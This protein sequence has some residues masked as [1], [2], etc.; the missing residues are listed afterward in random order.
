MNDGMTL[1]T[2]PQ[3]G[4][5]Y[6]P[7]VDG[8]RAFA[9]IAVILYHLN[10]RLLP[11]GFVGVDVFFV[12]SGFVVTAS[13]AHLN[14]KSFP[15]F[16]AFFYMRRIRRIYP[17]LVCCLLVTTMCYVLFIPRAWLSNTIENTGVAAF[18]GL[19]NVV[20][21]S[22]TDTYFS[23]RSEYNPFTHTWSLGVEEQFYLLFPILMYA[24]Q[25]FGYSQVWRLRLICGV[26]ILCVLSLWLS[27]VLTNSDWQQAFYGLPGR[28]WELGC[29]MILCL[30]AEKWVPAL[31]RCKPVRIILPIIAL[32]ATAISLLLPEGNYFPFPLA[33]IPVFGT[34]GIIASVVSL[35]RDLIGRLFGLGPVVFIGKISYS[36]YLWHWPVFVLMKWTVGLQGLLWSIVAIGLTG[37]LALASYYWVEN[38]IRRLPALRAMS[39]GRIIAA[40]FASL[41]VLATVGYE[42]FEHKDRLS[43]TQTRD[44]VLWYPDGIRVTTG[45]RGCKLSFQNHDLSGVGVR[46]FKPTSCPT[47]TA[48]GRLIVVGDSHAGAYSVLLQRYALESGREVRLYFA[49][50]CSFLTLVFPASAACSKFEGVITRDLAATVTSSDIVFLPSLRLQRFNDEW[51]EPDPVTPQPS[52]EAMRALLLHSEATVR[53]ITSTG[54]SVIF[55]APTPIFRSPAFRC[56]DWFN[57]NNPVC[58]QGFTVSRTEI[59]KLRAPVLSAMQLIKSRNSKVSIWD[60]LPHLCSPDS[61]SA[62]VDGKPLFFDGDHLSGHGDDVLLPYFRSELNLHWIDVRAVP[63]EGASI[64]GT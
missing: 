48:S 49:P 19:S 17:A 62:I 31:R 50:G 18:F 27:G 25:R 12:I 11:G 26:A 13:I 2:S 58:E 59:D 21:G 55:E 47:A 22:N 5:G 60:P 57:K 34:A 3:R 53:S 43:L 56:A 6:F 10:E 4:L 28:F 42:L 1:Q 52:G 8:L 7:G 37:A 63:V 46:V 23:P 54:A 30:T 33:L 16:L 41:C 36:L 9:V 14:F 39:S 29:G 20:L 15:Q 51:G 24:Y 61:C 38:P 64:H 44:A 35:P 40:S 32:I 45:M